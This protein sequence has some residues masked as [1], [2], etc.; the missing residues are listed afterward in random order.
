MIRARAKSGGIAVA[1]VL[2]ASLV[3]GCC[4]LGCGALPRLP[5]QT[6]EGRLIRGSGSMETREISQTGFTRL[7]IS[8]AFD[9][10]LTRGREYQVVVTADDN[11]W[12]FIEVT[13]SG[14]T[15]K[16]GLE[17]GTWSVQ[18]VTLEAEIR[19][20]TLEVLTLSGA[21]RVT[22]EMD[23]PDLTLDVSGASRVSLVGDGEDLRA[24]TSG[25][26][27]VDLAGFVVWNADLEASGA[28]QIDVYVTGRLDAEA[29]GAS[30]IYYLGDPSLGRIETSGAGSV[31]PR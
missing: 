21:S 19:M 30:R 22:G 4:G 3:S 31:R 23:T 18:D 6:T 10:Y 5:W 20:P 28:S 1:L 26:S 15:L 2:V 27:N 13:R 7:E 14:S 8:H 12:E 16:L 9:V 24:D 17:Q 11:L 29:S 25:A